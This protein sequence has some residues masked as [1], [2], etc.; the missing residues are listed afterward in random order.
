[1]SRDGQKGRGGSYPNHP[2]QKYELPIPY[3]PLG[4]PSD[5]YRDGWDRIFGSKN[6]PR[7]AIEREFGK[8]RGCPECS[9]WS[10]ERDVTDVPDASE[11]PG[12]EEQPC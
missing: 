3:A 11:T 4:P 2:A 10:D 6:E 12:T 8:C 5:A 7:C 1:M 9:M